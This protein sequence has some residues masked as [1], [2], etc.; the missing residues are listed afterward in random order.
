MEEL[1]EKKQT[2]FP[3]CCAARAPIIITFPPR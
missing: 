2:V 3:L 1:A